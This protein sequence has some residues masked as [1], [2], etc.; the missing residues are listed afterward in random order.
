MTKPLYSIYW[1]YRYSQ[2]DK[3]GKPL[4]T[5]YNNLSLDEAKKIFKRLWRIEQNYR[6][7]FHGYGRHKIE[8]VT[9]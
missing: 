3:W 6:L 2:S 7:S 4:L 5:G 8:R 9:R 1:Q